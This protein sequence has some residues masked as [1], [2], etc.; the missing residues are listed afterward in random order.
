MPSLVVNSQD[1]GYTLVPIGADEFEAA[2]ADIDPT[3]CGFV[4]DGVYC[5]AEDFE[6]KCAKDWS[7][8]IVESYAKP[9]WV[10]IKCH[11]SDIHQTM[12]IISNRSTYM[13]RDYDVWSTEELDCLVA[14]VK[15]VDIC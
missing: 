6:I 5:P 3:I 11:P 9:Y 7:I 8:P 2:I 15:V 10:V 13:V 12:A 4:V 14:I 1:I